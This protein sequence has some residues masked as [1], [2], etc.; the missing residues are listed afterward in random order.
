MTSFPNS[1]K[2]LFYVSNILSH[3]Q[4]HLCCA[5]ELPVAAPHQCS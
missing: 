5:K 3:L 1:P 2:L 4:D